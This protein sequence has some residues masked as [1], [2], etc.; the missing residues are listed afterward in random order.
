MPPPR[1]S[2]ALNYTSA[3]NKKQTLRWGVTVIRTAVYG[4]ALLSQRTER[5][6][7]VAVQTDSCLLQLTTAMSYSGPM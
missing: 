3:A 6:L 4:A 2:E 5:V 1:R 7:C